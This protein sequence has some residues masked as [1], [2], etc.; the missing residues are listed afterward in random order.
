MDTARSLHIVPA[1]AADADIASSILVEA[2]N[3]LAEQGMPM[4]RPAELTPDQ[5][6]PA[7]A[8]GEFYLTRLDGKAVGTCIFQWA[9]ELY[10]PD[11]IEG[12][13]AYI[14]RLAVRRSVAAQGVATAMLKWAQAKARSAGRHYLRLDC[15][16]TRARLC[17]YYEAHGFRPHSERVRG[18]FRLARYELPL[19]AD[20]I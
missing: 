1:V 2:A 12:E 13:A 18:A 15:D 9:D 14:H 19:Q 20:R 8:R 3:W 5:I 10:W 4:W 7:I 16:G 11:A 6:S 17:G